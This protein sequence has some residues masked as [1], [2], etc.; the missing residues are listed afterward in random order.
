MT[1]GT[2]KGASIR[3]RPMLGWMA[4]RVRRAS[5][6]TAR[7]ALAALTAR[8]PARPLW[9]SQP[10]SPTPAMAAAT[11]TA[12]DNSAWWAKRTRMPSDPLQLEAVVKKSTTCDR[13][14]ISPV[15]AAPDPGHGQA[16]ETHDESVGHRRQDDRQ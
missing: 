6:G 10:P 2:D 11:T 16:L 3:R 4:R 13:K 12:A 5:D 14:C 1:R 9:P 8:K 15:P 7:A